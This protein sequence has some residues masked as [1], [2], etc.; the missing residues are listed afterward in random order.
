M[1]SESAA[2]TPAGDQETINR[3]HIAQQK[4]AR[5]IGLP[6][7]IA[8]S[9]VDGLAKSRKCSLSVI[10]AKAGIQCSQEVTNSWTPFFNGVTTFYEI[11]KVGF[12]VA[13]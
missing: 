9:K 3:E 11:V 8:Q 6:S 1:E 4:P 2:F 7:N 13:F 5:F 10:P 12:F